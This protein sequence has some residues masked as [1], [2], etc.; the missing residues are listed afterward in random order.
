[1]TRHGLRGTGLITDGYWLPQAAAEQDRDCR[2]PAGHEYDA[3]DRVGHPVRPQ[4]H[5][6]ERG[7]RDGKPGGQPAQDPDRPVASEHSEAPRQ[8]RKGQGRRSGVAGR[9]R[10]A[11]D[12]YQPDGRRRPFAAQYVLADLHAAGFAR[13]REHGH[14]E[15]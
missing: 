6:G 8:D 10:P 3:C 5:P 1:V 15:G 7:R 2:Q 9:E 11:M 4:L 12:V 14:D 13:P